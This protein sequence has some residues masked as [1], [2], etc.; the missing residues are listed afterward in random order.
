LYHKGRLVLWFMLDF[1]FV[2]GSNGTIHA[3]A[4][5]FL[6]LMVS[7]FLLLCFFLVSSNPELE[8]L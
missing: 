5:M 4:A 1:G 3:I 6:A 2:K 8:P 7:F